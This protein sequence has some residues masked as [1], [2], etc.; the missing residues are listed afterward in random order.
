MFRAIKNDWALFAGIL[1]LVSAGSLLTTLLSIRGASIGFSSAE[2]GL[3]Q[4]CYPLGALF[5]SSYA[6]KLIERVG[7]I[8]SFGALAS[9]CSTSA[10][11]H[12]MSNDLWVWSGMRFLAGL[13]F[14]G[15]FV[16][17]ESW[18]NAKAENRSRAALLSI[19][20]ITQT[21]GTAVGQSL[22]GMH[23]STGTKLFGLTS[24]LISLC[25][26]PLLTSRNPAPEFVAAER[27]PM[28][29]VFAISPMAISG[30]LLSGAMQMSFYVALPLY[31]LLLGMDTSETAAL[32][33]GGALAGAVA[34]FPIGWISDRIDRRLVVA[35]A[36]IMGVVVCLVALTGWI[37]GGTTVE[38]A[39]IAAAI[40]PMY[41]LCIAHANDHLAPRQIVPAS[42]T[43]VFTYY[44]GGL[45]GAFGGP[46]AIGLLG[47][48]G[49]MLLMA[50]LAAATAA[51][52]IVRKRITPPPAE[53]GRAMPI[54]ANA[55]SAAAMSPEAAPPAA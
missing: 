9:L 42:G 54:A 45:I 22:A 16:I 41:S 15:M 36:S 14:P 21:L 30:A 34:Q 1:L 32:L 43:L 26:I 27:M 10:V 52:A 48:P 46:Y 33:V 31:G 7:H 17:A 5:G 25:L 51:V 44:V 11:I 2:I 13:C 49:F 38:V 3:I 35:G 39:L 23:D 55:Q 29:K 47:A 20:F 12:L 40:L 19:Y 8:R 53:T 18:L 28:R 37:K 50:V 24:I 4:A 6:P